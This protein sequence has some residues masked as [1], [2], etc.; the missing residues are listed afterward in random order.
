M[1]DICD[2]GGSLQVK[3]SMIGEE[4][5]VPSELY[6]GIC[7]KAEEH[8]E[9]PQSGR[10]IHTAYYNGFAPATMGTSF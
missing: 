10:Y 1:A 4:G 8:Y 7:C 3:A 6:P 2:L 5:R 9:K